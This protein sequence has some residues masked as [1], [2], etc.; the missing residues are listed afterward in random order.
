MAYQGPL[1]RVDVNGDGRT[2]IKMTRD[3]A[4]RY[5]GGYTETGAGGAQIP[6]IS[7]PQAKIVATPGATRE[8]S[9]EEDESLDRM[10]VAQL[11]LYAQA[12]NIEFPAGRLT[13]GDMIE[14]IRDAEQEEDDEIEEDKD[15]EDEEDEEDEA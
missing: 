8:M 15:E 10:T 2:L 14:A 9:D 1:V 4:S 5:I 6:H 11:R 12:H 3:E 7:H 13:R